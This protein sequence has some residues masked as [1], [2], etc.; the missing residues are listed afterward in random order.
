MTNY[1]VVKKLIG[2]I[3]PEGNSAVDYQR[4]ENL[5]SMC[6]LMD[7]IHTDIDALAYSYKDC[8]EASIKKCV[9]YA[10]EFLNKIGI[11]E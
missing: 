1:D 6:E 2:K 4:F 8:H 5:K 10:N 3:N 11:K 9:D 7:S